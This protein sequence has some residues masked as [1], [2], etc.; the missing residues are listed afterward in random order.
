MIHIATDG[1][2]SKGRIGWGVVVVDWQVGDYKILQTL[3]GEFNKFP[4]SRQIGGE[5][6]AVIEGLDW[7]WGQ[8]YRHVTV[9][10][11]FIG[12]QKWADGEW[13][14]SKPVSRWYWQQIHKYKALLDIRWHW[15]RGHSGHPL[16]ELADK[17]A[18]GQ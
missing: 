15:T 14:T 4:E 12:I 3:A 16:N 10:Y 11:D 8:H 5:L 17:L 18:K 9:I 1:S 2:F 13:R 7:C 6:H